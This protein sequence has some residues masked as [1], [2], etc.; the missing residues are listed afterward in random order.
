V[1]GLCR[2]QIFLEHKQEYKMLT[3][4]MIFHKRLA[5]V[6]LGLLMGCGAFGQ[7]QS[8]LPSVLTTVDT[9]SETLPSRPDTTKYFYGGEDTVNIRNIL[10]LK[11]N[12]LATSGS[13]SAMQYFAS[14]FTATAT[15]SLR[16]WAHIQQIANPPTDTE[17]V[18]LTV[19]YD[20]TPG[21]KYTP[22]RYLI[23]SNATTQY[24]A[25]QVVIDSVTVTGLS[26]GWT[27]SNVLPL[28]LVENEM[29][30]EQ[31]FQLSDTLANLTP[32]ISHSFDSV[33][34]P[35]QLSVWWSFPSSA[36][37]NLSQLEYAWVENET[38][39]FY[40][41]GG[42]FDT[43]QLFQQNSTRIDIN[44]NS[45]SYNIPLLFD[46]DS[47]TGG[48]ILYYRVRAVE[49]SSDGNIIAGPWST[50]NTFTRE[51]HEFH[52]NW[53]AT[54]DF[55]ENAKSKS[56]VQYY[57]GTLRP[58]QTV[59]KDNSTGNTIVGQTIYD[60]QG[61]PN[62]Q[63][64]PTPTNGKAIQFFSNFNKFVN[65]PGFTV[66]PAEYFDL[67]LPG[68][69]GLPS[70]SLDSTATTS[71]GYTGSA[72]Y[73]SAKNPWIDSERTANFIPDAAGYSYT[74]TRYTDDP[75]QRVTVQGGVGFSHQIGN[76]H[77]TNYFYGQPTQN[78]LDALFGTEAGNA[79][80]YFKNMVQDANGQMSVTYVD[81]H[82]RTIA[83]ALAGAGPTQM[84]GISN[85]TAF[86]P[87][88]TGYITDSLVTGAGNIVTGDSIQSTSTILLATADTVNFTYQLKPAIVQ[89]ANATHQQVCFDCKYN[90]EIS[91]RMEGM[92]DST[93][94]V[95]DFNNLQLVPSAQSC[96][97]AEGFI[98]GSYTSAVTQI[99]FSRVLAAG[100]WVVRKTL[101]INDSLFQLR[102]DS[103]LTTFLAQT[104]QS[105]SDSVF[106]AMS[107]ASQCA[108][109]EATRNCT[110]CQTQLGSYMTFK[111]GYLSSLPSNSTMT[112]S[113]IH[114]I[115]MQDSLNCANACGTTLLPAMTTLGQLRQQMLAD[116]MPYAG[117]YA[118]P[119]DS[120][121]SDTL[122]TAKYNIFT[123]TYTGSFGAYSGTKPYFRNPATEP[124]AASGT[125]LDDGDTTDPAIYPGG[126]ASMTSVLNTISTDSFATIFNRDWAEQLLVYHP[127]YK[128][129]H[130][131]ETVLQPEFAYID[132]VR[133]I[134][135]EV[136]ASDSGYLTPLTRDPFFTGNGGLGVGFY[137]A[138]T[139]EEMRTLLNDGIGSG[140]FS[141]WQLAN[142]SVLIDTAITGSLR[143]VMIAGLSKTGIDLSAS[144][145]AQKDAIWQN[146]RNIYLSYRNDMLMGY[147]NLYE[148]DTLTFAA[149][150]EL[151]NERRTL[152]FVTQS[153][154]AAQNG[155]SSW[156]NT[157]LNPD[158][159]DSTALVDSANAYVAA[160]T[161][162]PCTAQRQFW[163][164]RLEQCEVLQQYLMAHTNADTVLVD[165]IVNAILDGMVQVCRLSVDANDPNGASNV[166]PAN[167]PAD[168]AS[169]E[170]VVDSVLLLKGIDVFDSLGGHPPYYFCNPYSVD[171]PKPYQQNPP[172]FATYSQTAD[173]CNC[174]QWHSLKTAA[175][176]VGYDSTSMHSMNLYMQSNYNDSLSSPL[177]TGLQQ[178]NGRVWDTAY[179]VDSVKEP[180]PDG[181]GDSAY[182]PQYDIVPKYIG[183]SADVE[184]PAFLSCGYVK[185]CITCLLIDTL[186]AQF[187]RLFPNYAGVPYTDSTMDTTDAAQNALWARYL[188]YKTGFSLTANDYAAAYLNC[189]YDTALEGNLVLTDRTTQ[190][191]AGAGEPYTYIATNTVSFENGYTSNAGDEFQTSL[192]SSASGSTTAMCYL[193]PP[194]TYMP[195]PDTSQSNPCQSIQDQANYIG[196][197]LFQEL[198]DSLTLNFDSI[199]R[200]KCLGAQSMEQFYATYK[201]LEYHYTLYYYD[202]AGNLLKTLPPDG[203]IPNYSQ[204]YFAAVAAARAAKVDLTNGTNIESLATQY[205]YNTLNQVIAQLS[206][207]GGESHFWYDRLGRLVVSQNAKQADSA[208]F[209]YTEYDALGRITEVGQKPQTTVMTQT[210]SQ[211]TTTLAS[212]LADLTAGGAKIQITRTVYDAAYVPMSGTCVPINGSNLRNRV[213]YTAVIDQENT[214]VPEWRAATFYSYDPHGNVDTL[215]QDYDSASVMGL[216]HNRFKI[217]TYDYDLIS[218]KVNQVSY[219]PGKVDA[220]YHQYTYDAENR[221]VGVSTSRDSIEW[222]SDASYTYYR[223]GPLA[224]VELG[225]L[226]LQGIDYAYTLQGWLKSINPSWITPSG[227]TDQYD[228]D[229]VSTTAYFERDA[230]KLNL[231]YFDDGTYTD[232]SPI[233]PLT[234]Y[235]QGNALTSSAKRNL[236]N[237][238]IA[239]QALN[240]RALTTTGSRDVGPML[241]NYGYDQLNRISS[242]DAWT[243]NGKF[244]PGSS[245][246]S[247]YAERYTYD[248]NGN[249]LTL[250]RTGDSA[251]GVAQLSYKYRYMNTSGGTG[252][253]VPGQAPTSGVSRLTNQLSSIG[254]ATSGGAPNSNELSNQSSFNYQYNEIGE[255]TGDSKAQISNVVWN[256][257]G[258]I[259][260]LSDSGNTINFTYD[261]TGNRISK[262]ETRGGTTIT[263]WYVRDAQGNVMSVYTQGNSTINSGSL[264]QSEAH[265]YGSNRLGLL[266]LSVNCTSLSLPDSGSLV[267]GNKLFELTNHLG[268]V[269]ETISDKKIQHTSDN[270]TVDYYLADVIGAN[271]YYSF[272]MPMP[273]RAYAAGG[274]GNYRYGFNGKENDNEVKGVGDQIDYGMRGY[275]PR[276]GRFLSVDPLR[277]KYPE[278][279]PYQFASNRPIQGID[280]DGLEFLNSNT[281]QIGMALSF[282]PKLKSITKFSTYFR[283]DIVPLALENAIDAANTCSD[284]AGSTGAQ[285]ATFTLAPYTSVKT[286]S[287]ASSIDIP[288]DK[289]S[290]GA[291]TFN[292]PIIPRNKKEATEQERSGE[293]YTGGGAEALAKANLALAAIQLAGTVLQSIGDNNVR[294]IIRTAQNQSLNGGEAVVGII[295]D[296]INNR[297]LEGHLDEGSLI[298][299]AN[300]L[301]YGK[302]ILKTEVVNNQISL[303]HDVELTNI[304]KQLWSDYFLKVNE[305]KKQED[306]KL[307]ER[308]KVD[309]IG[310]KVA[311]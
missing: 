80:H 79:T 42:V 263:T 196:Q 20:P 17:T 44:Y 121:A 14:G 89:F 38:Q 65:E 96:T 152:H 156:W 133:Q 57:D 59:T 264:T 88:R 302:E 279:T 70:P 215:L 209:S 271:D 7:F 191:P 190:A 232:F 108:V 10:R 31:Y 160:N 77:T 32:T 134:T 131:A 265:L 178:C 84:T 290:V 30:V 309:D 113:A 193:A 186:T 233:N 283:R 224:R 124:N 198:Q 245:A 41:V 308:A 183:L 26:N 135:S 71:N 33:N 22:V 304:G 284:C 301:L 273:G 223:H 78:E 86:Y 181:G 280:R 158:G 118:L 24:Q 187:R 278:L 75:T 35:D 68:Q 235:L 63:I 192:G 185:P 300:Y 202:Q 175:A 270:S 3:M 217:M 105:L 155:W 169:F 114:A 242:M 21:N 144:T 208:A 307:Q 159:A 39:G 248:P 139:T 62:V 244:Q 276:V 172:L 257:Y 262:A 170:Q 9:C 85:N 268:N 286:Q 221:L 240:I 311:N 93:P 216:A 157:A 2:D 64:L 94:I 212:W 211:D 281:S 25:V 219:Q 261:A 230:Y 101:S 274:A 146:F 295:Q 303:V 6:I 119:L 292:M 256:V 229:G 167:L 143:N 227:T 92:A 250:N 298:G 5:V 214:N 82:G 15:I 116:M 91:L 291:S 246:L 36:H 259:L 228:S 277:K 197:L 128:K 8:G 247:D 243:A 61:R 205:R 12:E 46:A 142:A 107:T 151:Q 74:E 267:R 73:Y 200:A 305:A 49:V 241:Y 103:A 104:Q 168:P 27:K 213:A 136:A 294:A 203:A 206:P 111:S 225:S 236:Y 195:L 153:E 201:P 100:S 161:V 90:L 132:T 56:V 258:K 260:S 72:A 297:K 123:T 122:L 58:R 45:N 81:M 115:Y 23:L 204:T 249:I 76:G 165:T 98:G 141:I 13:G 231:N 310:G 11:I 47:L 173:S 296:A 106:N 109:P 306:K 207:D 299:L 282:D 117:Q 40:S 222:E 95:Y 239:S 293:Y 275:D 50:A 18:T 269:L 4:R 126:K 188:N 272:G 34:H 287:E 48:G 174:L 184:I 60:F 137:Y 102:E 194:V 177:W 112:D 125:Y 66:N 110:T 238:N 69:Q 162:D 1:R 83:T 148:Q 180:I 253:Y 218:G 51:G 150:T 179:F 87:S 171:Y 164:G 97:M 163:Q 127:E 166:N 43:T 138:E 99:S 176:A 140:G 189:G 52:L 120:V 129:L 16:M 254:V 237:G 182:Y 252:E 67:S 288:L 289:T 226:G 145:Q 28:L 220:F 285:V 234:G 19:N 266:N 210:I 251:Q 130:F 53:Q 147:I 37:N 149:M 29:Q 54:T 154:L 199:Y 55:A 255:L